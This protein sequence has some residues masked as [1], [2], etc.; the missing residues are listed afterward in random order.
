MEEVVYPPS[1]VEL[2]NV[3]HWNPQILRSTTFAQVGGF[4]TQY[5]LL[6]L[7]NIIFILVVSSSYYHPFHIVLSFVNYSHVFSKTKW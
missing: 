1:L 3:Y 7:L 2:Q 6:R 4:C 5:V